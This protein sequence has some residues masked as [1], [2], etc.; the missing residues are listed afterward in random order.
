MT[1]EQSR[2]L[3]RVGRNTIKD[4]LSAFFKLITLPD[5]SRNIK[6]LV[7]RI[8]IRKYARW[9]FV[10]LM[11]YL[12][13]MNRS[14][15]S[16]TRKF[17]QQG[18]AFI[19]KSIKERMK[20]RTKFFDLSDV[21]L[22]VWLGRFTREDTVVD[23]ETGETLRGMRENVPYIL[24]NGVEYT[25][26]D[27]R[28][29]L[30]Y[31]EA[32]LTSFV[33]SVFNRESEKQPRQ[34]SIR[35]SG[36]SGLITLTDEI[37]AYFRDRLNS[38]QIAVDGGN[39]I[40]MLELKLSDI[41]INRFA[42]DRLI[43]DLDRPMSTSMITSII[44]F[45]WMDN[46]NNMPISTSTREQKRVFNM[47]DIQSVGD[48]LI[49][50]D[51]AQSLGT[52]VD[53]LSQSQT[54]MRIKSSRTGEILPPVGE[55]RFINGQYQLDGRQYEKFNGRDGNAELYRN[56][57]TRSTKYDVV[58]ISYNEGGQDISEWRYRKDVEKPRVQSYMPRSLITKISG[59][60]T[61]PH[62]EIIST[63]V[64]RYNLDSYKS[65][66]TAVRRDKNHRIISNAVRSEI[67]KSSDDI[68]RI[69]DL[70]SGKPI[71]KLD[72]LKSYPVAG[73]LDYYISVSAD[74][75]RPISGV[76]N[77]RLV[78]IVQKS[79]LNYISELRK[80]ITN[81]SGDILFRFTIPNLGTQYRGSED[82]N[83]YIDIYTNAI[84][85]TLNSE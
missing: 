33:P 67:K 57:G 59:K 45:I 4:E 74:P 9:E 56:I 29:Y 24:V 31:Y 28:R 58:R 20:D 10:Y 14:I 39:Y 83:N 70:S 81:I 55:P 80:T 79:V 40:P 52:N 72:I 75:S 43:F 42:E 47:F 69:T 6:K 5:K 3:K 25:R 23:T 49:T 46:D 85:K 48:N 18:S 78:T 38:V 22:N 51:Y 82:N 84:I 21:E 27:I 62:K 34:T 63:E 37:K 36:R 8:T 64:D 1:S 41:G 35:T 71:K 65:T 68:W 66:I 76:M 17:G 11:R 53:D 13:V 50:R 15:I 44:T 30:I 7:P 32:A 73:I 61:V 2:E 19:V 54:K 16:L 60:Y 77:D 12:K 26:N